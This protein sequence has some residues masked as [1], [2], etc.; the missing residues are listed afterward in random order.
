MAALT[1]Q[2]IAEGLAQVQN[3]MLGIAGK[4]DT[5]EAGGTV[6]GL[7]AET[8]SSYQQLKGLIINLEE[9]DWPP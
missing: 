6:E 2:Q 1:I 7:R 9:Q 4:I 5:L 3:Q 8:E